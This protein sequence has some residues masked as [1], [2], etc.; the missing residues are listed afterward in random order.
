M[1]SGANVATHRHGK[2]KPMNAKSKRTLKSA[3]L[4][5]GLV[6]VLLP[7]GCASE[8]QPAP[9]PAQPAPGAPTSVVAPA[10]VD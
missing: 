8:S 10:T 7:T 5:G 2:G 9:I 3:A 1:A 6:A 4:A